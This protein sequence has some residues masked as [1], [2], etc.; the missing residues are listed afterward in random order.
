MKNLYKI[1]RITTLGVILIS[2]FM[3]VIQMIVSDPSVADMPQMGKW[4]KL[5]VYFVGAIVGFIIM[6]WLYTLLLRNNDNYKL[7]LIVN[8]AIGLTVKAILVTIIYLIA[9]KTNVWVNGIAGFIGFG[10]LAGLNWMTLQIS[11]S[12]KIKI[13]VLTAIWFVLALV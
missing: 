8:M 5:L 10:S 9:G 6:Y 1:D 11:Q 12:D 13:S 4:L 3:S 7:K 2:I